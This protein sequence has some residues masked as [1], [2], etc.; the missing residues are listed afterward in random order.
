MR[1]RVEMLYSRY[2]S[3]DLYSARTPD[4]LRGTMAFSRKAGLEDAETTEN[5]IA[6]LNLGRCLG[7]LSLVPLCLCNAGIFNVDPAY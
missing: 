3:G 6:R 2:R 1:Y 7:H 5:R 4:A